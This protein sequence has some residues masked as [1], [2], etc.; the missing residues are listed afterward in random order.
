MC[1]TMNYFGKIEI[2]KGPTLEPRTVATWYWMPTDEIQEQKEYLIYDLN[3][4]IG[5]VGG[6]LGL[7]IGFSFFDILKWIT[8][9]LENYFRSNK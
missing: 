8:R 4:L 9:Y 2:G 7:F 1:K 3:G 6:T 5:F